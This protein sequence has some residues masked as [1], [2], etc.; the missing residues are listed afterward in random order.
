MCPS[1]LGRLLS[2]SSRL[3]A[4]YS[5]CSA[6]EFGLPPNFMY[7]AI[8]T[9]FEE[10]DR[11]IFWA[12]V[13]LIVAA[14]FA[15]VYFLSLSVYGVIARKQAETK[16]SVLSA[17][18]SLLESEYSTLDKHINLELAHELG[19]IDIAAPRY[20]SR[21]ATHDAFTLRGDADIR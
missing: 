13:G 12:V 21:E 19:Y 16:I 14:L 17:R 1:R 9:Q 3:A 4:A 20:I 5:S 11:R 8:V 6:S 18:V 10:Y 7:Q 2:N 15:Y